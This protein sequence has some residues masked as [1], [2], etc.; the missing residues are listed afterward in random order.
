MMISCPSLLLPPHWLQEVSYP[1]SCFDPNVDNTQAFPQIISQDK[2]QM[3]GPNNNTA[4][5]KKETKARWEVSE[6][7]RARPIEKMLETVVQRWLRLAQTLRAHLLWQHPHSRW[8]CLLG[9]LSMKME[10]VPTCCSHCTVAT[11][12]MWDMAG[13]TEERTFK[14]LTN[15]FLGKF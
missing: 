14:K 7:R 2:T 11:G 12:C 4:K 3:E 6:G 8:V 13:G 5:N 1:L 9:E 10:I 15:V